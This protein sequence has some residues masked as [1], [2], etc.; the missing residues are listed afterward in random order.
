MIENAP[1]AAVWL[2]LGRPT[3]GL[4]YKII[5]QRGAQERGVLKDVDLERLAEHVKLFERVAR[6]EYQQTAQG[7]LLQE[8]KADIKSDMSLLFTKLD[9]VKD[10]VLRGRA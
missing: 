9:E 3:L 4:L 10:D 2:G 7:Q 6:V 5:P 1:D 8:L